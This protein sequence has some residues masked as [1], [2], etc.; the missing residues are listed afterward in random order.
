MAAYNSTRGFMTVYSW[1]IWSGI[2]CSFVVHRHLSTVVRKLHNYVVS[3]RPKLPK[4]L[5]AMSV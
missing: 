3:W 5:T 1:R 2:T 4:G